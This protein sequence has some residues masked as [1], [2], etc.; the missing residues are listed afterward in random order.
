[1]IAAVRIRGRVNV[2]KDV[3]DTLNMLKL[4]TVNSCTVMP[5]SPNLK[6]ML[7]KAKDRITYGSIDKETFVELLKKRG[8]VLGNKK[9][10]EDYLKKTTKFDNFENFAD[11]VFTNKTK[12]K[13]VK[14][15]KPFFRL[16]PPRK[17]MKSA[18]L[19]HPKGALGFRKDGI[20][21]FLKRMI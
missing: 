14:G 21:E 18:R 11:S 1:M 5:D 2:T 3:K 8:R 20:N 16:N 15:L 4:K 17:G 9:L 12:L 13:D 19:H 6:G 10:T 7:D